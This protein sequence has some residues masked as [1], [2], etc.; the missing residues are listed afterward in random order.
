MSAIEKIVEQ[1]KTKAH[2]EL[3][4]LVKNEKKRIDAEFQKNQSI[5]QDTYEKQRNKQVEMIQGK[6]RQLSNRQQ[7]EH[8]QQSLNHKQQLL[9]Q[10]FEDAKQEM[11]AWEPTELQAFAKVVLPLI[12]LKDQAV[13]IPG[14]KSRHVYTADFLNQLQ[15]PYQLTYSDQ[16]V[17]NQ[18]GFVVN[19]QG[20]QY[21]CLF[22]SL[23]TD[24][25]SELSYELAQQLFG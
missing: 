10:L 6:Y 9:N 3:S 19:S 12:P 24:V 21:N 22:S 15:L 2:E 13:F 1:M 4:L 17:A 5:L 16:A 8:R 11:E 23:V 18:A 25:Q 14:E 20:V 7:M